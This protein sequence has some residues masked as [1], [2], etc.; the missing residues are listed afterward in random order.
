LITTS[1]AI[2]FSHFARGRNLNSER[3]FAAGDCDLMPNV[4]ND[5]GIRGS[6]IQVLQV[7]RPADR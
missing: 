2:V 3:E 4:W 6:D 5:V 7:D 1:H